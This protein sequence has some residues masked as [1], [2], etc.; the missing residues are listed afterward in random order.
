MEDTSKYG[1]RV[2][3]HF[4]K[5]IRVLG[6]EYVGREIESP[7]DFIEIAA[8]GLHPQT[9]E[10]FREYFELSKSQAA[11]MLHVSEPTL[12]RWIKADKELDQYH[13][14]KL[15]ELADLYLNGV[16]VF[17]DKAN[18]IKWMQLPNTA[19]GGKQPEQLIEMPGGVAKVKDLLGRIE[20]GVYS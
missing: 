11:S 15:F 12:Y 8:K 14:V 6:E 17:Q 3:G 1:K 18:F 19:L 9:I 10:N 2:A 4:E 20:H 7:F 13:G 5:L 16:E